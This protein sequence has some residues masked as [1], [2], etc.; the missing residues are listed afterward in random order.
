MAPIQYNIFTFHAY[1]VFFVKDS[2]I[3]LLTIGINKIKK[4]FFQSMSTDFILDP[5][6]AISVDELFAVGC[7]FWPLLS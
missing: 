6:V 2:V 1:S 5:I 7:C 4:I 3:L